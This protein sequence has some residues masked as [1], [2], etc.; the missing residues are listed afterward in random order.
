MIITN[1]ILLIISAL[2]FMV[3]MISV[4]ALGCFL[5]YTMLRD[6]KTMMY[7]MFQNTKRYFSIRLVR[8]GQNYD[9]IIEAV[10]N[11]WTLLEY[12]PDHIKNNPDIVLEAVRQNGST[13]IKVAIQAM[14]TN[15]YEVRFDSV[16]ALQF[17]SNERKE[18]RRI[19]LEAVKQNGAALQYASAELQGDREI[20]LEAVKN[21]AWALRYASLDCKRDRGILLQVIKIKPDIFA[22][23]EKDLKIDRDFVLD[24][25]RQ[26]GRSLL[27]ASIEFKRDREIALTAVKN[28]GVALRYLSKEL[29]GDR[30]IV[31]EA[32]KQNGFAL[33]YA[34]DEL[35]GDR[36]IVLEAVKQKWWSI[37]YATAEPRRDNAFVFE[38]LKQVTADHFGSLIDVMNNG[39]ALRVVSAEHRKN[40][41][42][43]LEAVKQNGFA[44]KYASVDLQGDR[45]IV[46][47]AIKQNGEALQFAST[48]LREDLEIVDMAIKQNGMAIMYASDDIKQN[49]LGSYPWDYI[50]YE[51]IL[52]RDDDVLTK[53]KDQF[54]LLKLV[55]ENPGLVLYMNQ[56]LNQD[57][58]FDNQHVDDEVRSCLTEKDVK[59]LAQYQ[60]ELLVNHMFLSAGDNNKRGRESVNSEQVKDLHL[61][62]YNSFNDLFQTIQGFFPMMARIDDAIASYLDADEAI[63]FKKVNKYGL[64][65]NTKP[66]LSGD[67]HQ[68]KYGTNC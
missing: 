34:S 53:Q 56:I 23:I 10:R 4:I 15:A 61:S 59:G 39:M 52:A 18:D 48:T 28:H 1:E 62:D 19:V 13:A 51:S 17:A 14:G 54:N 27:T 8:K 25:V 31:F 44:L 33:F 20:V 50:Q 66:T 12:A 43:V 9:S 22:V 26:S 60:F 57:T 11:D 55:S 41:E 5:M 36:E 46:S 58:G 38:A 64:F 29:R 16:G 40:R 2:L 47:E 63:S 49:R 67:H 35:K 24:A 45:E 37:A 68:L 3:A 65:S 21:N 6:T 7:S 42:I 30:Q 32:V